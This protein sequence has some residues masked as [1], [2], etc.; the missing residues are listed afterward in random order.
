MTFLKW[1]KKYGVGQHFGVGQKIGV[2]LNSLLF[3]LNL[4]KTPASSVEYD[5]IVPR[6]LKSLDGCLDELSVSDFY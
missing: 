2:N 5:L 6:M 1:I 4:Q 3:N